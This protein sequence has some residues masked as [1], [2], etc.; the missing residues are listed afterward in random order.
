MGVTKIDTIENSGENW[1]LADF[2]VD[3]ED[4]KHYIL[5]T[6]HVHAS[7]LFLLGSVREQAELV[8]ILLNE[9]WKDGR[10]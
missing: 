10:R 2:G 6:D 3:S 1:L 5:T 7:E 4:G 8:S 9:H